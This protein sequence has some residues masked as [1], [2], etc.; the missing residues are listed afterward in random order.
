MH[1]LALLID[2]EQL[3][4]SGTHAIKHRFVKVVLLVRLVI[5]L[6][7]ATP[8]SPL[9]SSAALSLYLVTGSNTSR[10]QPSA[11]RRWGRTSSSQSGM[12]S[13]SVSTV[14]CSR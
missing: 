10:Q 5:F 11:T 2:R 14:D 7:P 6:L 13:P 9:E 3:C 1:T 12:P 8:S 4:T